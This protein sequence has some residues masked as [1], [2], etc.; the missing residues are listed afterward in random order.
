MVV[1]HDSVACK[2]FHAGCLQMYYFMNKKVA[3]R[4]NLDEDSIIILQHTMF[5][6]VLKYGMNHGQ[7]DVQLKTEGK[8]FCWVKSIMKV[9]TDLISRMWSHDI[10]M[11]FVAVFLFLNAELIDNWLMNSS[12]LKRDRYTSSTITNYRYCVILHVDISVLEQRAAA[13]SFLWKWRLHFLWN[14]GIH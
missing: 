8:R 5:W 7:T 10:K 11:L 14:I 2:M 6:C 1:A 12:Y 4:I 9:C 13:S 3:A